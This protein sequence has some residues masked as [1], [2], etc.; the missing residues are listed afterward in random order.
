[1]QRNLPTASL[2]D[3]AAISHQRGDLA[4]AEALCRQAIAAEA[5]N[6][7]AWYMLAVLCYLSGRGAESL[8]AADAALRLEPASADAF[9]LK[10]AVQRAM[11]RREDACV[12]F[13]AALAIQPGNAA[14]WLNLSSVQGDLGRAADALASVDRALALKPGDAEAWNNRGAALRDLKRPAEALESCKRAL[15]LRPDY[16]PALRNI[17]A[18]LCESFQVEEGMRVYVRQALLN[19][20]G[21]P[22]EGDD[23]AHKQRHDVQQR[24]Y[25]AAQ[26][27]HAAFHLEEGARLAGVAVNPRNAAPIAAQWAD[28][29]P[30]IVVI[31]DLL[32]PEALAGL[33]R[34]CWGSTMWRKAYG[35]GYL[36][37]TPETGFACPLLAQI[38]DELRAVFPSIFERHPLRYLW[39]FKYDSTLGG[40]D[41]HA[42]FAAVNVNFWI[43]P[44]EANLNP[45]SGGLTLWD[46]AAPTEW[47]VMK[48]N[49]DAGA[50]R[51]FL[52][53]TGARAITIPYRANR[54]VIFDSDLFHKTDRIHF[55]DGYLNRRINVTM[56]YGDR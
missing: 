13:T 54:A 8:D 31:D 20:N 37:A 49:R 25:L 51:E 2:L 32:S 47:D 7:Q 39:G 3:Q 24:E 12:S 46:V 30:Q 40:I 34:F 33:R 36:G 48:Y 1:M 10:G 55:K 23:L 5:K 18:L 42:D 4:Q 27:I 28:K 11:A 16:V 50:S 9:N 22:Q 52:E 35:E 14:I 56:L 43:T 44:D 29:R 45:E 53:R 38:S 15:A 41:V 6:F 17:G 19:Q 21:R 26:N